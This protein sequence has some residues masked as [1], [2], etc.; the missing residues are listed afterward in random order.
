MDFVNDVA[1]RMQENYE[2]ATKHMTNPS[3]RAAAK[4]VAIAQVRDEVVAQGSME[5]DSPDED[6]AHDFLRQF[7]YGSGPVDE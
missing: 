2:L 6:E 5:I 3:R 7:Y 4:E 1:R